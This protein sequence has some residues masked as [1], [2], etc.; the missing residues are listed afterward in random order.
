MA[1]GIRWTGRA[2]QIRVEVDGKKYSRSERFPHSDAGLSRAI[3]KRKQW[4]KELGLG[5]ERGIAPFFSVVA[6]DY[7]DGLDMKRSSLRSATNILNHHW[8][9]VFGTKRIDAIRPQDIRI[10]LTAKQVT[11][12]TKRNILGPL[13]GVFAL[14]IE[15]RWLEHNPV[16]AV[17]VAKHQKPDIERFEPEEKARILRKLEGDPL[18]FF[19]IAFGTGMRPPG[20]LLPLTWEDLG[21]DYLVVNKAVVRRRL[22]TT[23]NSKARKVYLE[24]GLRSLLAQHPRRFAGGLIFRNSLGGMMLDA[25]DFNAAWKDAL[26][27][28]RVPYRHPYVCRHTRASEMI[29]Q[30]VKPAYAAKQLGHTVEMFFRVYADWLEKLDAG[31]QEQ[32]LDEIGAKTSGLKTGKRLE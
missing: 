25:D 4:L 14:A 30:G 21:D 15:D 23:K 8:N 20:E 31:A 18:L 32:L 22:T 13:R 5:E 10:E 17:K 11:G 24:P 29:T 27:R 2:W 16:D 9:P 3:A 28:A 12:K 19:Q 6:Q 7:L 26:K 1:K